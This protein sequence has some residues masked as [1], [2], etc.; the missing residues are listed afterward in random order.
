MAIGEIDKAKYSLDQSLQ[1][2]KSLEDKSREAN[3]LSNL[4]LIAS[5]KGDIE[6]ALKYHLQSLDMNRAINHKDHQQINL[7]NIGLVLIKQGKYDEAK[8][9][10]IELEEPFKSAGLALYDLRTNNFSEAHTLWANLL[11]LDKSLLGSS[12]RVTAEYFGLGLASEGLRNWKESYSHFHKAVDMIEAERA[13][14]GTPNRRQFLT[15]RLIFFNRLEPYEGLARV[16]SADGDASNGFFWS[17]N[18]KSRLFL[19]ALANKQSDNGFSLPADLTQQEN[20]VNTRLGSLYRQQEAAFNSKNTELFQ[21]LETEIAEAK[22]VQEAFV[23]R[24]RRDYPSYAAVAYPQ[25][26]HLEEIKLKP[27]EVLLEYEVTETATLGWLV[28]D[29]KV[30]KTL[31]WPVSRKALNERVK[32]FHDN[33]SRPGQFEQLARGLYRDLVAPFTAELKPS[34]QV[35]IVPDDALGTIPFEA[36]V[37]D[38]ATGSAQINADTSTGEQR[39]LDRLQVD[40]AST[41][42]GLRYFGDAF[43]LRYAQSATAL[44]QTRQF[45][46]SAKAEGKPLL[47]VA[48]PVFDVADARLQTAQPLQI[49]DAGLAQ[50]A[51]RRQ[52]AKRDGGAV[53]ARLPSTDES[54]GRLAAMFGGPGRADILK[55]LDANEE[56][57]KQK[58]GQ[59]YR[60]TV[61][62]THGI[63]ANDLPY[64][65]EPALV[66]S[67]VSRSGNYLPSE[68]EGSPGFLTL[69]EVMSLKIDSDLV[70]LTACNTGM[71]RDLLGE[72]AMS[73]GR[74][75]QYAGVD[76]V[77]MSLWSVDDDST[78]ILT[79]KFFAHLREGKGK[80]ESLRLARADVRQ[81]YKHPYYW[82]PFILVGEP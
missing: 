48:D 79:E 58:L 75:F 64:L 25:P 30:V 81:Q 71:G 29:G 39:G 26:L 55:G 56:M 72:G 3:A 51:I 23:S 8:K 74:G 53:F 5:A 54:A 17:E 40:L 24:L 15:G 21:K 66:L 2:A 65:Q 59:G 63:L 68:N 42:D 7:A 76:S 69:A 50:T 20:E 45:R 57:V 6:Q 10:F 78:N 77:L 62:A 41:P 73:M 13:Q 80:L 52:L 61:F 9:Y 14:L 1:I 19:E 82:A 43:K 35:I 37:M 16:A 12:R 70:A 49:A 32:Q 4:A 60:Y 67:L 46:Q 28:R 44:V 33:L 31:N 34:D 47:V 18:T 36:L 38:Q 11:S 22:R 27:N